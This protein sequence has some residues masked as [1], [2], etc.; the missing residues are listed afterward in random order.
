MKIAYLSNSI[1]PSKSANSIHVMK[2]CQV[3]AKNGHEVI[4]FAPHFKSKEIETD[5]NLYEFY[6]VEKCFKVKKLYVSNNKG[7]SFVYALFSALFV[8]KCNP[9][10]VYSRFLRGC[11][12]CALLNLPIAHES[13]HPEKR[14][15]DKFFIS[16][17]TK[18]KKIKKFVVIS[19]AL[20]GYYKQKYPSIKD[21]LT[22]APDGADPFESEVKPAQ[23]KS[24]KKKL[25]IGY[26]GHMYNGRGLSILPELISKCPW[27]HFHFVGGESQD[28]ELWKKKISH[29]ENVT[30]YGYLPHSMVTQYLLAFDILLAPYQKQVAVYG[31]GNLDTSRWM[32]PLK[33]FE[34]MAAGKAIVASDLSVLREIL[35]NERNSL[36]CHSEKIEEWI[37]AIERLRDGELREILGTNAKEEFLEKYSWAT[38]G[39]EVLKNF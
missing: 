11:Y 35:E 23:L 5:K 4:L 25:N 13:H 34:Y 24:D 39:L 1:I 12:L 30:F 3:F 14:K 33:I 31:S 26:V 36:L 22:V 32:S 9:D 18:R 20:A 17:L 37:K 6:G 7:Y 8:K 19:Q 38:R 21:K 10:L 2:M 29:H 27:A 16:H 28:I 15:I